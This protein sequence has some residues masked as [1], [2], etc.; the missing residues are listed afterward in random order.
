MN[1][2]TF[3]ILF[4]VARPAAGKSEIIDYLKMT[5]KQ[6]RM[7]RFH[8]GE[9]V[10]LDDFPMLWVWFEED[11]ILTELGHPRLHTDDRESNLSISTNFFISAVHQLFQVCLC[12]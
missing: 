11:R 7:S 1:R 10:E 4:L 12:S 5:E 3:D 2:E 6:E 9:F 8:I